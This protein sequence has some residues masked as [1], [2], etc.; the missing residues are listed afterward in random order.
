MPARN[1]TDST[2]LILMALTLRF[3]IE[4]RQLLRLLTA[5]RPNLT[6]VF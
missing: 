4:P 5:G 3:K 6:S 2:M 1:L